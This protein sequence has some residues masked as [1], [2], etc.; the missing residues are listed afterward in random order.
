MKHIK[1]DR[2]LRMGTLSV[3]PATWRC[4]AAISTTVLRTRM[5]LIQSI[6]RA[7]DKFY[8]IFTNKWNILK[9]TDIYKWVPSA[10]SAFLPFSIFH[11]KRNQFS[12]YVKLSYGFETFTQSF[13]YHLN[14]GSEKKIAEF[15]LL[16]FSCLA[17]SW[18]A[19]HD[20]KTEF[21]RIWCYRFKI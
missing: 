14:G 20:L 19:W 4:M 3:K 10:F 7:W 9:P 11:K 18:R 15:T 13:I 2:Q 1:A 6:S 12:N 5:K 17:I 16:F 21:A 8:I